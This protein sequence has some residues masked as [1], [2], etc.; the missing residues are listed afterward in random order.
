MLK[1]NKISDKNDTIFYKIKL[2]KTQF[3]NNG[4]NNAETNQ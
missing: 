1:I 2:L 4:F 3:K